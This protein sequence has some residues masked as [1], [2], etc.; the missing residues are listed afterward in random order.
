[1]VFC[2][3]SKIWWNL[4]SSSSSPV[5]FFFKVWR[6]FQWTKFMKNSPLAQAFRTRI[7]GKF[8]LHNNASCN[9]LYTELSQINDTEPVKLKKINLEK[10]PKQPKLF[11]PFQPW[12]QP[13]TTYLLDN[14]NLSALVFQASNKSQHS[15]AKWNCDGQTFKCPHCTE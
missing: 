15:A 10:N 11:A 5:G 1:M 9:F 7:I 2:F 8:M 12:K 4:R 14:L 6:K 3:L 13:S